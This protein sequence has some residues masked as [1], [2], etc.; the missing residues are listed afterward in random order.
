V[1]NSMSS[2]LTLTVMLIMAIIGMPLVV[3]YTIGVYWLFRGK[4][5]LGERSY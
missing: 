2:P 1:A 5:S 3:A 4:V